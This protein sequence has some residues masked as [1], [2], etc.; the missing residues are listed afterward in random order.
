[1]EG[2]LAMLLSPFV[3]ESSSS[4]SLSSSI[5]SNNH[6]LIMDDEFDLDSSIDQNQ[7]RAT[8]TPPHDVTTPQTRTLYH[9][10][11]MN[12]DDDDDASMELGIDIGGDE[13]GGIS[14]ER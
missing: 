1:M 11:A 7:I 14:E 3:L 6:V 5:P 12:N 2:L 4:P 9:P 13:L 8:V 10:S